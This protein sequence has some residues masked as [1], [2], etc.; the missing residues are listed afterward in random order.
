MPGAST[1]FVGPLGSNIY[2]LRADAATV[3][4]LAKNAAGGRRSGFGRGQ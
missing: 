1:S 3:A 2:H 4:A